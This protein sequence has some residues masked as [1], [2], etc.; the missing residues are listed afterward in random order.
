[1]VGRFKHQEAQDF[2]L[3]KTGGLKQPYEVLSQVAPNR[4]AKNVTARVDRDNG[5]YWTDF[6]LS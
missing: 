1:M 6:L 5:R 3:L 4:P 2:R